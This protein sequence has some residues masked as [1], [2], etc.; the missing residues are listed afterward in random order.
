MEQNR[1]LELALPISFVLTFGYNGIIERYN[2]KP[3]IRHTQFSNNNFS[4]TKL[5]NL[6]NTEFLLHDLLC[7]P[8]PYIIGIYTLYLYLY[9]IVWGLVRQILFEVSKT[10]Y[11]RIIMYMKVSLID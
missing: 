10:H 8:Y 3:L 4:V 7:I 5:E 6:R 9:L 11:D 1:S 2:F